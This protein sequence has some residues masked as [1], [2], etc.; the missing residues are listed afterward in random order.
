MVR[1]SEGSLARVDRVAL[2]VTARGKERSVRCTA[3]SSLAVPGVRRLPV[4]KVPNHTIDDVA[5]D[6]LTG[7]TIATEIA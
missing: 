7:A 5:K 4:E 1:R 2:A 6:L 3:V